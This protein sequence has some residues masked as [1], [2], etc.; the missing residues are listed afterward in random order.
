V[1]VHRW[2]S[3]ARSEGE[4]HTKTESTA[5]TGEIEIDDVIEIAETIDV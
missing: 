2:I 3:K 1:T 4:L 5:V